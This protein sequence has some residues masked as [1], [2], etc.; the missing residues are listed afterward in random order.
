ME[1][2]RQRLAG[3]AFASG[4]AASLFKIV[5]AFL[6]K[7]FAN[8]LVLCLFGP[9][10]LEISPRG[11]ARIGGRCDRP[12]R[13]LC[14]GLLGVKLDAGHGCR[15]LGRHALMGRKARVDAVTFLVMSQGAPL[16]WTPRRSAI[17]CRASA[18]VSRTCRARR[19][20]R[21]FSCASC[22]AFQAAF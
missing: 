19:S 3:H 7:L 8:G 9:R 20:S 16:F 21:S 17:W 2:G 13:A 15:L 6:K 11:L 10:G 5:R 1:A 18:V 4:D 12:V 22:M 14:L